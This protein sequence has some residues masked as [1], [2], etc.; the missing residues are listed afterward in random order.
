MLTPREQEVH[1]LLREGLSN[2]RIAE[3]LG[4]TRETAKHHVSQ[5]ISKLGVATREEAAA[6]RPDTAPRRDAPEARLRRWWAPLVAW[7]RPLTLAKAAGIAATLVAVVGLGVLA[8]GVLRTSGDE[9]AVASQATS[10]VPASSP[11]LVQSIAEP[12]PTSTGL[13][14]NRG[15]WSFPIDGSPPTQVVAVDG[16]TAEFWGEPYATSPDG[17]SYAVAV[18]TSFYS[19]EIHIGSM[20]GGAPKRFALK[21][22]AYIRAVSPGGNSVLFEGFGVRDDGGMG[23]TRMY[24]LDAA[25]G[26]IADIGPQ[27]YSGVH[28]TWSPDGAHLALVGHPFEQSR[29]GVY[30]ADANG[31][32]PELVLEGAVSS[33]AWAPDGGAFATLV[34]T[35]RTTEELPPSPEVVVAAPT[36]SRIRSFPWTTEGFQ[37]PQMDWAP[38]GR[39]LAVAEFRPPEGYASHRDYPPTVS[40]KLHQIRI[41]D[42]ESGESRQV[43][44]GIHPA[45]S[46]AGDQ[47]AFINDGELHV[48]AVAGGAPRRLTTQQVP[49]LYAPHWVDGSTLLAA[50]A[51]RVRST[52][53]EVDLATGEKS[54]LLDGSSP[55]ISPDGETIAFDGDSTGGG[56][57]G[58][59]VIYVSRRDGTNPR[60]IGTYQWSDLVYCSASGLSWSPD[61]TYVLSRLGEAA[62][63]L[64]VDPGDAAPEAKAG[65]GAA[66]SPRGMKLAYGSRS[67]SGFMLEIYDVDQDA[68][69]V[70][71]RQE[72]SIEYLSWSPDGDFLAF[73]RDSDLVSIR[74]DGTG[75]TMLRRGICSVYGPPAWSPDGSSLA[76]ADCSAPPTVTGSPRPRILV[77]DT[78][79][80]AERHLADGSQ[81]VWSP[82]GQMIAYSGG[83]ELNSQVYTVDVAGGEPRRLAAGYDPVWSPD[84]KTLLVTSDV[85]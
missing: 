4:I 79:T 47:I 63:I 64:P 11:T 32:G 46:P 83:S 5:I 33:A 16:L 74:H 68:P 60:A 37:D 21:T 13:A 17:L 75:E 49:A 40:Q 8:W 26:T 84:G 54:R 18:R 45:W 36:G 51:P 71:Q 7:A 14:L 48:V 41:L 23:E 78:V 15:L 42:L 22:S 39:R 31:S 65:C 82:D 55:S 6:W 66:W 69:V 81:P 24:L 2:R 73:Y 44:A 56:L 57:G 1:A 61:G 77:I 50:Y 35:L 53:Y 52:I 43:A 28:A 67:D 3:R 80:G 19:A 10:S 70:R 9:D 85:P 58:T 72:D 30:L 76:V 20:S 27:W 34:G 25:S 12:Q 59:N 29:R 38:E 62:A